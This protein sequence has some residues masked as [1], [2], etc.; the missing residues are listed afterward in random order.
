MI[1]WFLSLFSRNA[2][3]HKTSDYMGCIIQ[4]MYSPHGKVFKCYATCTPT[5]WV[6]G[7]TVHS[8]KTQLHQLAKQHVKQ[9]V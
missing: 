7:P 8:V 3:Q 2:P 6:I 9:T 1:K 5:T 4:P